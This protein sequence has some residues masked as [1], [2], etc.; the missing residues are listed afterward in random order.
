MGFSARPNL[1]P[2]VVSISI[3]GFCG[4]LRFFAAIIPAA[5]SVKSDA[6]NKARAGGVGLLVRKFLLMLAMLGGGTSWPGHAATYPLAY[7]P[8]PVDNP[9][10]GFVLDSPKFPHS[11]EFK[12]LPLRELMT[13]SNEYDW[14]PLEA[15]LN[16]AATRGNQ[17]IFRL[18]LEYP[19]QTSG[20][21]RFL[22]ESG[23]KLLTT[24]GPAYGY[25]KE[26][27]IYY[28]DYEDQR[29]RA[30]LTNFIAALGARLDGDARVGFISAG[31]LGPWG[32]WEM[33][34]KSGTFAPP[35][36]Q[37]EVLTAFTRSFHKTKIVVRTP[38]ADN[39]VLPI[40]YHDDAF[41]L[42][43]IGDLQWDFTGKLSSAGPAAME[44][45]RMQAVGGRINPDV[46]WELWREPPRV[47]PGQ[48][49]DRCVDATHAS[50]LMSN[51]FLG[52]PPSYGANEALR[53]RA[54]ATAQKLGYELQITQAELNASTGGLS[55]T[56][57]V[58]N[59][60]VAPFYYDWPVKVGLMN[61][62][63]SLRN[64]WTP[65][66]W[67]LTAI[68]PGA[69]VTT[70]RFQSPPLAL[71]PGEYEVLVGVPNPLPTGK[72]LGF[73]NET[74]DHTRPGWLSLG[75]LRQE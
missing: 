21:P 27:T 61:A 34:A 58:T 2:S 36:V 40:G 41:A 52:A 35:V 1:C 13:G 48:E 18:W 63:G 46:D 33:W 42:H 19:G 50:W 31:L 28:P 70:W 7:A 55:V 17:G 47:R 20:V 25:R 67:K 75:L 23:V 65:A 74:R 73:A 69:A 57:S 43:T 38:T 56:L 32:E 72:P 30:A 8:A 49:I 71:P 5:S 53:A 3:I 60:G 37:M 11:L 29:L 9:L 16:G 14:R 6:L 15:F 22:L 12:Y 24:N 10:K 26:D 66:D 68:Q 51:L 59:R 62:Q 64:T 45:W 39:A 4:L 54:V 44:K